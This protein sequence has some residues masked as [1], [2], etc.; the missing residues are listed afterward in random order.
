MF[1]FSWL[2]FFRKTKLVAGFSSLLWCVSFCGI[3]CALGVKSCGGVGGGEDGRG[4]DFGIGRDDDRLSREFIIDKTSSLGVRDFLI[5]GLFA[6]DLIGKDFFDVGGELGLIGWNQAG[7]FLLG[8]ATWTEFCRSGDVCRLAGGENALGG[9]I[10][11]GGD[12]ALAGGDVARGGG[13][14]ALLFSDGGLGGFMVTVVGG[15]KPIPGADV[16]LFSSITPC[17]L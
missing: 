1:I 4:L 2:D 17:I 14:I 16:N 13:D 11:L 12:M 10:A 3:L 7:E 6:C 5:E 15:S 9:D 8:V